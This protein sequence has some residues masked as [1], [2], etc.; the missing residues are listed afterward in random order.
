MLILG[1]EKIKVK[2]N[3]KEKK[4]LFQRNLKKQIESLEMKTVVAKM[5]DLMY[6]TQQIRLK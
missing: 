4:K 5:Q 1:L 6:R 2:N 3:F